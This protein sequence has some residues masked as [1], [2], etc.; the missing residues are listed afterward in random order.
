MAEDWG[1][2]KLLPRRTGLRMAVWITENDGL[3]HVLI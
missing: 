1:A 2:V 3:E